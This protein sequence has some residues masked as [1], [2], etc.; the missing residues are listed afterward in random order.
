MRESKD[1]T[2]WFKEEK[3]GSIFVP[4][5]LQRERERERERASKRHKCFSFFF[6][7]VAGHSPNA[8]P[9]H[10]TVQIL[11]SR[12]WRSLWFKFSHTVQILVFKCV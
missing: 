12:Q 2:P 10:L 9:E 11:V 3:W 8:Y 1:Y 6:L 7:I 4:L 5:W